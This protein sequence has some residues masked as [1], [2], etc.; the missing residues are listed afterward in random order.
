MYDILSDFAFKVIILTVYLSPYLVVTAF[1]WFWIF[2]KAG[3]PRWKYLIPYYSAY[4]QFKIAWSTRY[5]WVA[6]SLCLGS[7]CLLG[8]AVVGGTPGLV[9]SLLVIAAW[10]AMVV[11]AI[12][13]LHHLSQAF[14]NGVGFTLGLLFLQPIFLF[15]LAF[16]KDQQYRGNPCARRG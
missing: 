13:L 1:A 7:F 12:L 11:I 9:L 4:I 15:I 6:L 10:I 14:G 8:A 3:Q 5:F 16:G 2:E